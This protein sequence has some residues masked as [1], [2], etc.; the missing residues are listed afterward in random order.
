MKV[1]E[2]KKRM[3]LINNLKLKDIKDRNEKRGQ[4]LPRYD[5]KVQELENYVAGCKD[6]VEKWHRISMEKQNEI[7]KLVK[8]RIQQLFKFIFP[9]CEV[10]PVL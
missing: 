8:L 2:E 5:Q 4:S 7:R 3:I 10:K 9:V 1:L 6:A